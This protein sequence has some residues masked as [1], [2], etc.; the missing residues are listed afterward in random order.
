[1][2]RFT[3][4]PGTS[5]PYVTINIF[6]DKTILLFKEANEWSRINKITVDINAIDNG[7]HSANTF[8]GH[9]LAWDLDTDKDNPIDLVL[10]GKYLQ[11]RLPPPYEIVLEDTHVHIEFDTHKGR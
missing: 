5:N 3:G 1:M 9:S 10:L 4:L 7:K 8:H 11:M 6:D 2:L